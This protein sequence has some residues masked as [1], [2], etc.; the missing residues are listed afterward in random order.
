MGE[1]KILHNEKY[2]NTRLLKK[3]G[4]TFVIPICLAITGSLIFMSAGWNLL[5][6]S[7]SLS[8]AIFAKPNKD[9]DGVNFY[10]NNK[11]VSRPDIGSVFASIKI[12]SI[13]LEKDVVHGDGDDEL[14]KGIGHYAG[15]TLPG[16]GGNCILD[17]HRDT[18][19]KDLKNI[20]K[21]DSIFVDTNW[22][23]YE[24]KVSDIKV[25]SPDDST[26]MEPIDHEKLTLYTC[27]PFN[28]IGSAPKRFVVTG[29]FVSAK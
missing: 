24:Y 17:G 11:E 3:I 23:K 18:A 6:E 25:T 7:Y 15:S 4:V 8:T 16:E 1:K 27:Y 29:E 21:G 5:F 19:L 14:I 22:G 20:K 12:P 13:N 28:Y 10:I 2:T 9:V 26:V